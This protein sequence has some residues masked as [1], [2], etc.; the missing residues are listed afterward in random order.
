MT[1]DNEN[2]GHEDVNTLASAIEDAEVADALEEEGFPGGQG[3]LADFLNGQPLFSKGDRQ[4]NSVLQTHFF[5]ILEDKDYR[6]MLLR[7]NWM[8]PDEAVEWCAA[9]SQCIRYGATDGI[10]LLVDILHARAAG[11]TSGKS[12]RDWA[13]ETISHTTFNLNRSQ[14]ST[15]KGVINRNGRQGPIIE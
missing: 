7:A 6:A 2:D 9:M 8:Y 13:G 11:I 15:R 10:R 4:S 1:M 3:N 14:P 12:L 5:P